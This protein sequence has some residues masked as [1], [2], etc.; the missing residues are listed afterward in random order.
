LA[1][2]APPLAGATGM[3]WPRFALLSSLSAMLWVGLI[4]SAGALLRPQIQLL[5]P[6]AQHVASMAGTGIAV[7]LV[8]YIAWK[9]WQRRRFFRALRMARIS[10]TELYD[11]IEAGASPVIVDVRSATARTLEPAGT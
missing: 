11:L 7:L 1:I 8:A 4:L 3:A 9:W 2:I 5:M 10:V 6:H